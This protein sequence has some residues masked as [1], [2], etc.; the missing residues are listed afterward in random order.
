MAIVLDYE[1]PL[2]ADTVPVPEMDRG[3]LSDVTTAVHLIPLTLNRSVRHIRIAGVN[4][5]TEVRAYSW[6][7]PTVRPKI[8]DE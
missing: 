3:D 7:M 1:V 4:V 6:S 2:P 5:A 8:Q